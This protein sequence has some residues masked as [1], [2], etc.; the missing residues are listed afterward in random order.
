MNSNK[1]KMFDELGFMNYYPH[2]KS[3]GFQFD[4]TTMYLVIILIGLCMNFYV[5]FKM[6]RLKRKD[7]DRFS[8]GIGICLWIMAI[9]DV[10]SLISTTLYLSP[11]LWFSFVNSFLARFVCKI[12]FFVMKT[13][14]SQSMWVWLLMSGLR[15]TAAYR[16]LKYTTL[17]RIPMIVMSTTFICV[18]FLNVW[19]FISISAT[20]ESCVNQYPNIN[21]YHEVAYMFISYGIPTLLIFYM[22][23]AVLFCRSMAIKTSDPLLKIVINRPEKERKKSIYKI[24]IIIITCLTLNTPENI[25]RIVDN[26][27]LLS[28]NNHNWLI[29]SGRALSKL[30]FF[31]Q[32]AFNAFYLTTFVYDKSINTKT[33]SSRQLSI[34]VRVRIEES[35]HLIRERSSTIT[36]KGNTTTLGVSIPRNASFCISQTHSRKKDSV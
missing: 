26:F 22:D 7:P 15:Y 24:L 29:S 27:D 11:H 3:I 35:G 28:F 4:F 13:A 30:L 2:V 17:W 18:S 14:Y 31:S 1:K 5:I 33:N 12:I 20:E 32:F 23:I 21:K 19:L 10:S 25:F 8:N 16:P 9:S 6:H 34:S 36:G